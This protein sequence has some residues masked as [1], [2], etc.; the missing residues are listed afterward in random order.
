[1]GWELT[2]LSRSSWNVTTHL[3]RA[4]QTC[5]ELNTN[6]LLTE[7]GLNLIVFPSRRTLWAVL[8]PE[9]RWCGRPISPFSVLPVHA[10]RKVVQIVECS[11]KY[12]C[13]G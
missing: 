7:I 8:G 2:G 6:Y 11:L 4:F 1:M 3:R 9:V 10:N 5:L 13:M 12:Q